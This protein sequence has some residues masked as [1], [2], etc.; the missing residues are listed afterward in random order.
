MNIE[1]S[2]ERQLDLLEK[3]DTTTSRIE[4]ALFDRSPTA[5]TTTIV[6]PA[7]NEHHAALP[8]ISWKVKT[9][10]LISMLIMPGKIKAPY[11]HIDSCFVF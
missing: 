4:S 7:V 9:I 10:I 6:D 11:V 3:I 8:D 1:K 2:T 5:I